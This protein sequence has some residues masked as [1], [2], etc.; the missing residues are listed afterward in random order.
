VV[1]SLGRGYGPAV[2]LQDDDDDDD[3]D[4]GDV[5]DMILYD[6]IRE[7]LLKTIFC[8]SFVVK[9]G[10]ILMRI[11]GRPEGARVLKALVTTCDIAFYHDFRS[12]QCSAS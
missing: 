5:D 8:R 11:S 6:V 4:D 1:K 9:T 12:H 10:G 2:R 7:W 3:E